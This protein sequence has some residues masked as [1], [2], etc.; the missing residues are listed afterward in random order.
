LAAEID[1]ESLDSQEKR[2]QVNQLLHWEETRLTSFVQRFEDRSNQGDG[3]AIVCSGYEHRT[4][5]VCPLQW[6]DFKKVQVGTTI[7][8]NPKYKETESIRTTAEVLQDHYACL[9]QE[10]AS[11]MSQIQKLEPK[12]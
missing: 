12:D 6:W 3:G 4:S 10:K 1:K 7:F 9:Q 11:V 8:G 2:D 5:S